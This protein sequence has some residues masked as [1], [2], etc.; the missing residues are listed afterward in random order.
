MMDDDERMAIRKY[1]CNPLVT[2]CEK[3]DVGKAAHLLHDEGSEFDLDD[4]ARAL[5]GASYSDHFDIVAMLLKKYPTVYRS[6][7]L[8][9]AC[10][11]GNF[12]VMRCLLKDYADGKMDINAE[13]R[14]TVLDCCYSN[15]VCGLQLLLEAGADPTIPDK[16]GNTPL[17]IASKFGEAYAVNDLLH[18][19]AGR[20]INA[21][22]KDGRTALT[23]SFENEDY[24]IA[25]T[26][27]KAGA[28]P[29]VAADDGITPLMRA[30]ERKSLL[31]VS[32]LLEH[33]AGRNIN[34]R[35][36]DGITAL[37][38]CFG[39]DHEGIAARLLEAGADPTI[40]MD[41]MPSIL[42]NARRYDCKKFIG[43]LEVRLWIHAHTVYLEHH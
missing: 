23:S 21:T 5:Y 39:I 3:G 34:A 28:D 37:G 11:G 20:T 29:T 27:L 19:G 4:A 16:H 8:A 36:K 18:Y 38:H 25:I 10:R 33:G 1:L 35:N 41:G 32:S 26:L 9:I 6:D 42:D 15:N 30:C 13:K 2:A 14:C 24:R 17:M 43:L 12:D 22:G 40:R 7:A 31:M